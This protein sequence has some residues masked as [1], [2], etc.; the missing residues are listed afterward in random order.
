MSA[1]AATFVRHTAI[2]SRRGVV[3][4]LRTPESLMD[5]VLQPVMLLV[6]FVYL[7]GG[8]VTGSTH[9]YLQYLVPGIMVQT[10]VIATSTV[11]VNLNIDI[12]RGIFDRFRSMPIARLAP[13]SGAVVA[14]TVRY[15]LAAVITVGTGVA[16]GFRVHTSPPAAVVGVALLIA[17]A[18]CLCWISVTIGLTAR[19]ASATQGIQLVAFLPLTFASSVFVPVDTLPGWLRVIVRANPITQLTDACRG[20]LVEGAVRAPLAWT[21]AWMVALL[22]LFVPLSLWAY[23]RT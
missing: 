19:T 3:K 13:L 1:N 6:L 20:L 16:L 11:G 5:V 17:F 8:A 14:E 7:F 22:A 23:R 4:T 15:A 12:S 21:L 2:L 18:L 9:A 10:T